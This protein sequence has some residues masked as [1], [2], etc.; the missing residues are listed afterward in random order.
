MEPI[1]LKPVADPNCKKCNGTG[2]APRRGTCDCV[3]YTK[4]EQERRPPPRVEPASAQS[5]QDKLKHTLKGAGLAAALWWL[6]KKLEE[7]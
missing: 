4:V 6:N 1:P 3:V 2:N 7:K 5:L